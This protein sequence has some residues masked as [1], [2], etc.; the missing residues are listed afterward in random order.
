MF[1]FMA[2]PCKCR[3]KVEIVRQ[4]RMFGQ[5]NIIDFSE[6]Y[7]RFSSEQEYESIKY[8]PV[9]SRN[10]ISTETETF[11]STWKCKGFFCTKRLLQKYLPWFYFSKY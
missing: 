4:S 7:K 11:Y 2:T 9:F 3:V 5:L 10:G 6:I 1:W 8:T